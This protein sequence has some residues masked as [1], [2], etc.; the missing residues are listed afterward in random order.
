[1]LVS[2]DSQHALLQ[3]GVDGAPEL[4]RADGIANDGVVRTWQLADRSS[5]V[6]IQV[7]E[8]G[9]LIAHGS[10]LLS[11]AKS[12]IPRDRFSR[13]QGRESMGGAKVSL[14]EWGPPITLS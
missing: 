5:A 14:L 13:K 12:S 8:R 3:A 2:E 1:M 4:N 9:Q 6:V 10:N 7:S 11:P